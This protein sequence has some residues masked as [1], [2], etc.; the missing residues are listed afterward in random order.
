MMADTI[1]DGVSPLEVSPIWE[2]EAP[3]PYIESATL[4]AAIERILELY[5]GPL[6]PPGQLYTDVEKLGH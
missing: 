3:A 1:A 2:E 5:H 4:P 6:V